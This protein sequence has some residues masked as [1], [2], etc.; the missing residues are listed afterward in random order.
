MEEPRMTFLS[1]GA[2]LPLLLAAV[3]T[4]GNAQTASEI[5]SLGG[6]ELETHLAQVRFDEKSPREIFHIGINH[7]GDDSEAAVLRGYLDASLQTIRSGANATQ[8]TSVRQLVKHIQALADAEL[9]TVPAYGQ[10]EAKRDT[11]TRDVAC[12]R[13][14]QE[15]PANLVDGMWGNTFAPTSVPKRWQLLVEKIRW[16]EQGE[17]VLEKNHAYMWRQLIDEMKFNIPDTESKGFINHKRFSERAFVNPALATAFGRLPGYWPEKLGAIAYFETMSTPF[18]HR[19][20]QQLRLH[21]IDPAWYVVHRSIDNPV[22]GH[23]ADILDAIVDYVEEHANKAVGTDASGSNMT[24]SSLSQRVFTGFLLYETSFTMLESAA[25]K[26]IKAG[27]SCPNPEDG[28]MLRFVERFARSAS[29]FH[30]RDVS[31]SHPNVTRLGELMESAPEDFVQHIAGRC[32]LVDPSNPA[33]SKFLTLFDFG[34]PMYG[35]AT[36][37]DRSH[38]ERWVQGLPR[39]AEC[40]S[41]GSP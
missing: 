6:K 40:S 41:T 11:P 8:F 32:D 15:T 36:A 17:G 21:G 25:Q 14:L 30:K 31:D 28:W 23:S 3:V 38:I 12:E 24:E 34:G 26:R 22:N 35:V 16:E 5:F 33:K 19:N 29:K 10:A 20:I 13:L 37:D 9:A 7:L 18:S 1:K 2:L 39:P 27:S 4:L